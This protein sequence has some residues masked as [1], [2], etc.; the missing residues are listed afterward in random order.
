LDKEPTEASR[1]IRDPD[2]SLAAVQEASAHQYIGGNVFFGG[3]LGHMSDYDVSICIMGEVPNPCYVVD[4]ERNL[5]TM[6][7][8]E[9]IARWYARQDV[10]CP[11]VV[12]PYEYQ[13]VFHVGEK[14]ETVKLH[15]A[16]G[17]LDIPVEDSAQQ[18]EEPDSSAPGIRTPPPPPPSPYEAI[19]YSD[20]F[21]FAEAFRDAISK[22]P[23]QGG[24]IPDWLDEYK[25]VDIGAEI[26]GIAHLN[27]MYVRVRTVRSW[28]PA[29]G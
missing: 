28:P 7:P 13:E 26:G 25:V 1:H 9:F 12:T 11:D 4:I 16:G 14:R 20:A 10:A 23:D 22:L 29:F 21:D 2:W 24:G 8:P 3:D 15:H 18:P 17:V 5:L 6:E 19:G 27:R